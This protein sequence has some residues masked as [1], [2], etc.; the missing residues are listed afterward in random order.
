M[1]SSTSMLNLP[2]LG[3]TVALSLAL[4]FSVTACEHVASSTQPTLVRLID[5]SS[6]A[7]AVDVTV[8]GELLATNAGQGTITTYGTFPALFGALIKV[9]AD[10]GGTTLAS[11]NGTLLVGQQH[12]ILL[13]DNGATPPVYTL[14]LLT[15]QQTSAANGHSAFRFI[16]QA[17][18][19]GAVDIYLLP[20]GASLDTA[21]PVVTGLAAGS[22]SDYISFTSQTVTLV[23]TPTGNT[24]SKYASQPISF[25][26]G[27]VR[28]ALIIDTSLT[29][30]PPVADTIGN[31]VN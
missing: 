20:N 18:K 10:S 28:T 6:K 13:A 29:T 21:V 19:T 3:V 16:N 15:D 2:K 1:N 8:Q 27:E 17:I 11:T 14:T 23:V 24:K 26:G 5:A 12:S 4:S 31:D 25:N 22:L 7:A 30:A 9:T